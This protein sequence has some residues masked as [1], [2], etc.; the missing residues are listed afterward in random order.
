LKIFG[1]E[2]LGILNLRAWAQQNLK[3]KNRKR[4]FLPKNEVKLLGQRDR[5]LS[6]KNRHTGDPKIF[7]N[8]AGQRINF[9]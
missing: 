6:P 1:L 5:K 2:K 3:I 7:P 4:T 8:A 9:G